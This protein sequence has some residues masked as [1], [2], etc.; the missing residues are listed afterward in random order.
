MVD[1]MRMTVKYTNALIRNIDNRFEEVLPVVSA[2][3]IF[4]PWLIPAAGGI[5]HRDEKIEILAKHFYPEEIKEQERVEAERGKLKYDIRDWKN[6]VPSE[7]KERG[8]K[9][10]TLCQTPNKWY[11]ARV[12]QMPCALGSL[13]PCISKIAMVALAL[14][15]LNT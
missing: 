1:M 11:L 14:P 10:T 13:Y 3:S 6:A 9:N 7:I 4:D 8:R 15:I 5:K 2:F 12:M